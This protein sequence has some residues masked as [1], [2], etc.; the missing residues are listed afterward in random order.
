MIQRTILEW[1]TLQYSDDLQDQRTIPAWAADRLA[2]VAKSS[3]LGGEGGARILQHGRHSLRAAQVVGVIAAQDCALEILPKIDGLEEDASRVRKNLVHMLAVALDLEIATGRVTELGWQKDNLLEI[4]IRLFSEK[5]FAQVHRGLP[6]R[7][8]PLEDDLPALR[9]RL[10]AIRQFTTLAATPQRLACRYDD[11]SPDVPLNQIMKAAVR[12]LLQLSQ[13]PENQRRLR[14]LSFAFADVASVPVPSLRWDKV[15]LDRTNARWRELLNLAKLLLG[16]RFQ[17]TT[18]G[19][20]R[21]FSLLFEMNTLF[22]EYVGRLLR[23]ALASSGYSVHLQGGRLHCLTE[24]D[25]D[26]LQ[27]GANRFMTK[28]DIIIKRGSSPVMIIDTKWKRLAPRIDDPKQGVSQ[29]DV[30]QMM[31]YGRLYQC[32][33]LMLLY[34]HHRGLGD[35]EGLISRHRV[36]ACD[37]VLLSASIGLEDLSCVPRSLSHLVLHEIEARASIQDDVLC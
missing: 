11:L 28:P 29:A 12:R 6:R 21:G 34:P 14:E 22:E 4:L 1:Q 18:T 37:D 13:A 23:R 25:L 20:G 19:G 8:I 24:L 33:S 16:D 5:L 31:A 27:P 7:Y 35:H 30:Y 15:V 17:T 26:T 36:T 2:A 9:G 10:D 32:P 3:S